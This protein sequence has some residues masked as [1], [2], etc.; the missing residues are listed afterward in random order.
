MPGRLTRLSAIGV[1]W[2]PNL[3]RP[4]TGGLGRCFGGQGSTPYGGIHQ[5]SA[6]FC[7][8]TA[9]VVVHVETLPEIAGETVETKSVLWSRA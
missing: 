8:A 9:V 1:E 4:A 2:K 5:L 3:C 7:T 6:M